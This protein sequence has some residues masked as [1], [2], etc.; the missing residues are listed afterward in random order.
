[1]MSVVVQKVEKEAALRNKQMH[2]SH[3]ITRKPEFKCPQTVDLL[4]M[5][6]T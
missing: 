1:M 6:Q 3:L 2:F 4:F 5:K